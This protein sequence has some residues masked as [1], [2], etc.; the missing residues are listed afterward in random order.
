MRWLIETDEFHYI[1]DKDDFIDDD[2]DRYTWEDM[3]DMY[4]KTFRYG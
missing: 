4:Q 2:R 1:K 3:W